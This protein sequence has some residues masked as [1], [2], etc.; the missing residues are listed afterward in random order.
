ME[1]STVINSA[2]SEA[3]TPKSSFHGLSPSG[4]I[5]LLH[6]RK[7]YLGVGTLFAIERKTGM[8][9]R[10]ATSCNLI[11]KTPT[12]LAPPRRRPVSFECVGADDH[13]Q[14][15]FRGLL[16][17]KSRDGSHVQ[18][19]AD[20]LITSDSQH[21][22]VVPISTSSDGSSSA[23]GQDNA[24]Q[25]ADLLPT[26]QINKQHGT[27]RTKTRRHPKDTE[28]AI[29][30]LKWLKAMIEAGIDANIKLSTISLLTAKSRA[31]LER[32]LKHGKLPQPRIRGR[33]R[34][35]S[36]NEVHAYLIGTWPAMPAS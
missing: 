5:K 33:L 10:A 9:G 36:L 14:Y 11:H 16:W 35:W 15:R 22:K 25:G 34:Y 6:N 23:S 12:E 2:V 19:D 18:S 21:G 20:S 32:E 26:E 3:V 17:A 1:D 30:E 8:D 13:K 28:A 24:L 7:K 4:Y 31:T 29:T 27:A